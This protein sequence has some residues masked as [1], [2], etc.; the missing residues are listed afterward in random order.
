MSK[1]KKIIIGIVV[2]VVIVLIIGA[3]SLLLQKPSAL[4]ESDGDVGKHTAIDHIIR[5]FVQGGVPGDG[6]GG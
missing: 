5:P 2:G 6:G 4:G 3:S 1:P